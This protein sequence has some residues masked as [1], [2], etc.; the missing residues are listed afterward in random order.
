MVR[1]QAFFKGAFRITSVCETL[2]ATS[3][4]RHPKAAALPVQKVVLCAFTSVFG[5][6]CSTLITFSPDNPHKNPQNRCVTTF[7]ARGSRSADSPAGD[8]DLHFGGGD[9][10]GD[11]VE[12][13]HRWHVVQ[14]VHNVSLHH[15]HLQ[16]AGWL[17]SDP[18]RAQPGSDGARRVS[19]DSR[20]QA[21]SGPTGWG[22]HFTNVEAWEEGEGT[23]LV[24]TRKRQKRTW[25][26]VHAAQVG[27][28]RGQ[29]L[30]CLLHICCTSHWEADCSLSL[31]SVCSHSRAC[32]EKT[33]DTLSSPPPTLNY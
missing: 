25:L 4:R 30:M 31:S 17:R 7:L 15:L 21:A 23:K 16:S 2:L 12:V 26:S 10:A 18:R 3:H 24:D 6:S 13:V 1:C 19:G 22:S 33:L 8:G 9:V 29:Y 14:L 5:T 27:K 20:D 28:K 11:R 32:E